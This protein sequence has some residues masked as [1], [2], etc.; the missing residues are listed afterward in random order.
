MPQDH[1]QKLTF[2]ISA[3][4]P[5]IIVSNQDYPD[6]KHAY[7]DFNWGLPYVAGYCGGQGSR[8]F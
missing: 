5:Y 2:P 3:N 6:K 1:K 4:A 8:N 7:Q